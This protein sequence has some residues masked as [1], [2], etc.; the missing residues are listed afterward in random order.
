MQY[1]EV[2]KTNDY[3]YHIRLYILLKNSEQKIKDINF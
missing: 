3:V 2:M 1:D